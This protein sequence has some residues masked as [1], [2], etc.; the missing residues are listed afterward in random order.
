MTDAMEEFDAELF[1]QAAALVA[2]QLAFFRTDD[3]DAAPT[4]NEGLIAGHLIGS[5]Y[6]NGFLKQPPSRST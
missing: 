5:L 4:Q 1:E 3:F 2:K 6:A